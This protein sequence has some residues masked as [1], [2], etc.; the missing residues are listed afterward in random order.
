MSMPNFKGASDYGY[1]TYGT[2]EISMKEI[3]R[4]AT[5][6]S[7]CQGM[8]A[9]SALM[10]FRIFAFFHYEGISEDIFRNAVQ[11]YWERRDEENELPCSIAVLDSEI[12]FLTAAGEWDRLRFQGGIGVLASF[13]LVRSYSKVYTVHSLVHTWSR[14]R[15][16]RAE[17]IK[18]C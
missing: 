12:L 11:N 9:Q 7:S 14:D 4:R 18:C 16:P 13:A 3:E 8:A 10:L 2:W 1:T 15:I 5:N 6:N 17:V